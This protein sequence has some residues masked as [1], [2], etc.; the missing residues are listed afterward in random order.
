M[1]SWRT[2]YEAMLRQLPRSEFSMFVGRFNGRAVATGIMY[3][4]Q[5]VAAV[6][7]IST[8]P[9][10]RRRGIGTALTLHVMMLARQYGS[11]IAMLT[12]SEFG[13]ELYK[14]LGFREFGW[15]RIYL[16]HGNVGSSLRKAGYLN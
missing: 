11:R 15:Q 2:V 10:F 14:A 4:A 3:R 12:A 13:I 9:E 16:W 1:E 6:H 7:F 5:G 8:L